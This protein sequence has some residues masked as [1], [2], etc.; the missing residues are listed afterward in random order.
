VK[1]IHSSRKKFVLL[2]AI[3]IWPLLLKEQ[4]SPREKY[5]LLTGI[6]IALLLIIAAQFINK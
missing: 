4:R 3:L 5:F 6:L 2:D 1:A